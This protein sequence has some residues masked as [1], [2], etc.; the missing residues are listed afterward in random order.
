MA[1]TPAPASAESHYHPPFTLAKRGARFR[2]KMRGS[3]QRALV[4][5]AVIVSRGDAVGVL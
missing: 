2:V 3:E 1:Q 5:P 4:L